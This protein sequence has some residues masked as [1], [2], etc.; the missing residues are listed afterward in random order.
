[1]HP[2]Q[3]SRLRPVYFG[4]GLVCVALGYIG[5]ILPVMPST[6]FFL[7]ALWAFKRSS[8]QL[9]DWLMNRSF[10]APALQD[11]ERDRSMSLRTKVIAITMIW[12][13]ICYSMY[14]T[15]SKVWLP[16]LLLVIAISLTVYLSTRKT[17][18]DPS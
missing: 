3:R 14:K 2:E 18:T 15:W 12:A 9:E 8:P 16:A 1:M 13:S 6:V 4:L 5:A 7:I 11:W 10:V 17:K